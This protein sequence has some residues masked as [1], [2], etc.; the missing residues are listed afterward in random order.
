MPDLVTLGET[1]AALAPDRIGPLRHTRH[2]SLGIAGSES[3]VAIGVRRLG[4]T[5]AWIGRL[6]DDE[7]GR[8]VAGTLRS[9]GVEVCARM[10]PDAPTGLLLKERRTGSA[11]R[12]HYYRSGS[13]GSRLEPADLP[14]GVI[15]SAL[16]VHMSA[17]TP[18]LSPGAADT[19]SEVVR[20]ARYVSFDANFRSK[21]W[22]AEEFRRCV[23]GLLPQ[24][25]LLFA[26]LH[27]ARILLEDPDGEAEE[28]AAALR[29][30]GPATVVVTMGRDGAVSVGP[31]GVH[32]V[33]AEFVVEVDPVGAGDSFVAGYL[34]A[35]LDG[36][37]EP[38]RLRIASRTAAFSVSA[39]GDWEGLPTS[40][41]LAA[42]A[43]DDIIR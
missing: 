21:L 15:E 14:A 4:Y 27:E 16:V 30:K 17:I 6:G 34:S 12:V 23:L 9:E 20:R 37:P 8:L 40:E 28:L 10:D 25:D 36:A 22:S 18:A 13:A 29:T 19:T 33:A 39:D 42:S 31:S 1:M 3:T 24:V 5:A 2:L 26:S 35:L 43:A 38:Q 7:L 41:E 11:R 32:R